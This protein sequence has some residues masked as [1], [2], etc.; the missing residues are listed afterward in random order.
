[1]SGIKVGSLDIQFGPQFDPVKANQVVQ[2]LQQVISAVR[3]LGNEI[4]GG[5]GT[6]PVFVHELAN[7]SG[8]GVDHTVA[9]LQANQVLVAQSATTAHFAFLDFGQMARTDA[10]TFLAPANGSVIAFINGYWTAIPNSLGLAN[11][12]AD[13]LVMW[14]PLANAGAGGLEWA[15]QGV[16]ISLVSGTLSVDDTQL[17]HGHLLGLAANDHPQYALVALTPQ[18]ATP[19]D[20]T[21]LNTFEVGILSKGDIT[22]VGNLEQSGAE[23]ERRIQNTDDIADEGTWRMHAEPGQLVFS[24]VNDDGS[25]G[26][27]WLSVQRTGEL[28]DTIALQ[29]LSLTYNGFDVVVANPVA[30]APYL[31]V[32]AAGTTYN[33]QLSIGSANPT[34]LIGLAQVAG[35]APTWMRS[36]AAPPLS[37]AIAPVWTATHTYTPAAGTAVNI[38]SFGGAFG[39]AV[40]GASGN[41]A[42]AVFAANGN[43]ASS[44][45]V[46]GQ[47]PTGIAVINQKANLALQF[48]TNATLRWSINADGGLFAAGVTGGDQGVGTINALGLFVNGVAVTTPTVLPIGGGWGTSNGTTALALPIGQF[49]RGVSGAYTLKAVR[50]ETLGGPGNCVVNIWK[51]NRTAH[52]PPVVTDDITGGV[53]PSISGGSVYFNNTLSGWTTAIAA[54]D[55]FLFTLAS[56][57]TFTYIAISLELA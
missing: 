19:N 11:P 12:G 23:P 57:L 47:G 8:L 40:F 16:G 50:I 35:V 52:F 48:F 28:V 1:M 18:L 21:A 54:E 3:T 6:T 55:I 36:D 10:G 32:V 2:S 33:L 49:L 37:Q 15:L 42:Q 29:S 31:P 34:A 27:N 41:I 13:A 4:T 7:Q 38:N 26:E 25:D 43:L 9:G 24:S 30:G 56:V 51:A 46:I 39:F 53:S 44:G 20:F 22:L 45:V 5:G 14:D 17:T